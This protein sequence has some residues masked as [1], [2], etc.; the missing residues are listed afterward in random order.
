VR[1]QKHSHLNI[2]IPIERRVP[3]LVLS[4]QIT[5]KNV[6]GKLHDFASRR[7][8]FDDSLQ[9]F[10]VTRTLAGKHEDSIH[11]FILQIFQNGTIVRALLGSDPLGNRS[12]N[13]LR[14][15]SNIGNGLL[16]GLAQILTLGAARSRKLA[17][18][19]RR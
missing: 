13:T 12:L 18:P 17:A 7:K 8:R 14:I 4:E 15:K 9:H 2:L 6:R 11:A 3:D 10:G 1:G 5:A 16:A 19:R